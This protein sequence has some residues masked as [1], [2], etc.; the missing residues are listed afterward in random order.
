MNDL[1]HPDISR[2]E[3]NGLPVKNICD[4]C[5][6]VVITAEIT[7]HDKIICPACK[8][9]LYDEIEVELVELFKNHNLF[10]FVTDDDIEDFLDK[11]LEQLQEVG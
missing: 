7:P 8:D 6:D 9:T 2:A 1:Q 4:A 3:R 11:Q 10:G 5:G